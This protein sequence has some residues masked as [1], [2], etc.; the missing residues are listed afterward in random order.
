M[1]LR[2]QGT[3]PRLAAPGVGIWQAYGQLRQPAK[4]ISRRGSPQFVHFV[5]EVRHLCSELGHLRSQV[6]VVCGREVGGDG[7]GFVR[8]GGGDEHRGPALLLRQAPLGEAPAPPD[9][10]DDVPVRCDFFD[11]PLPGLVSRPGMKK[12]VIHDDSRPG[13]D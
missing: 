12:G 13:I 2:S 6:V 7:G 11:G 5:A 10:D 4:P 3:A 8:I 9:F 1:R